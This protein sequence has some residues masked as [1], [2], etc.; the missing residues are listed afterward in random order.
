MKLAAIGIFD[1]P[2]V[3]LFIYLC[4]CFYSQLGVQSLL[5]LSCYISS[6]FV[7]FFAI[8][9]DSGLFGGVCKGRRW[10]LHES[11]ELNYCFAGFV[12]A[13]LSGFVSMDTSSKHHYGCILC[14]Y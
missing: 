11:A 8:Y 12:I 14:T 9:R 3:F 6:F 5:L 10:F 13:T 2:K 1:I 7:Y 4:V